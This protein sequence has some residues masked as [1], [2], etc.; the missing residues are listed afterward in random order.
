MPAKFSLSFKKKGKRAWETIQT[1]N[2]AAPVKADGKNLDLCEVTF[3]LPGVKRE[4][5]NEGKGFTEADAG[6]SVKGKL[7]KKKGIS[8]KKINEMDD[9][10]IVITE[11]TGQTYICPHAWNVEPPESS[12][13]GSDIE[14]HFAEAEEIVNG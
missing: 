1:K 13:D 8:M 11:D 9:V 4:D 12:K 3:T 5:V 6:G 7:Y 10:T 2:A 14:F